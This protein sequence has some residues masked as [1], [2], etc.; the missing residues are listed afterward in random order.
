MYAS[1]IKKSGF[2]ACR[3]YFFAAFDEGKPI[4]TA[5]SI[6]AL[7]I[8]G[9]NLGLAREAPIGTITLRMIAPISMALAL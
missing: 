4:R 7:T 1:V 9:S 8:K 5:A 6:V 2:W 3:A